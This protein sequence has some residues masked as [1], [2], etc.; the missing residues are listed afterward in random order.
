MRCGLE[1][2]CQWLGWCELFNVFQRYKDAIDESYLPN[3]L[4]L[5][6][7]DAVMYHHYRRTHG[8]LS[9][10]DYEELILVGLLVC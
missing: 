4:N 2:V 5:R 8:E 7:R 9:Q 3:L 6:C 10:S 1:L